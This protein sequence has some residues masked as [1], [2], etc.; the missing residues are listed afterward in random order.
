[1]KFYLDYESELSSCPNCHADVNLKN[2]FQKTVCPRCFYDASQEIAALAQSAIAA[3]ALPAAT[4]VS[5]SHIPDTAGDEA[6]VSI[7]IRNA[8]PALILQFLRGDAVSF[9]EEEDDM[10]DFHYVGVLSEDE[11]EGRKLAL[12][13]NA[14]SDDILLRENI[15]LREINAFLA[16][17]PDS[18]GTNYFAILS[19]ESDIYHATHSVVDRTEKEEQEEHEEF[20]Y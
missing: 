13:A 9:A 5:E 3:L 19:T 4:E 6:W 14:G 10:E 20:D 11:E 18:P 2:D 16:Q 17:E 8:D 12:Y 7:S 1:M 15:T